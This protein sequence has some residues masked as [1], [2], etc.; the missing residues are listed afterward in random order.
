MNGDTSKIADN[1]EIFQNI[2]L[3]IQVNDCK[4]TKLFIG[5]KKYTHN[6]QADKKLQDLFISL[7]Y[8]I[9]LQNRKLCQI[10]GLKYLRIIKYNYN[11]TVDN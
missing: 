5:F 10:Q 11:S 1:Y 8:Q 9:L 2:H 4:N 3:S 7:S 6:S